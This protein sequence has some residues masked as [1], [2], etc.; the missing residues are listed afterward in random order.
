MSI[1]RTVIAGTQVIHGSNGIFSR[2][3]STSGSVF[4]VIS[5]LVLYLIVYLLIS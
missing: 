4:L 5:L 3:L 2:G 1:V